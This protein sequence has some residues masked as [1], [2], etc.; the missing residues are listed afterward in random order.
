ME[1]DGRFDIRQGLLKVSPCTTA[2][3]F[4]PKG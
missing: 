2:T 4:K 1:G 3:P